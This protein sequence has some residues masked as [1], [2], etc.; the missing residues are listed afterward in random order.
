MSDADHF[1]RVHELSQVFMDSSD[2]IVLQ[3]IRRGLRA[4]LLN[5][6]PGIRQRPE[7]ARLGVLTK[8]LDR[9]ILERDPAGAS[10]AVYNM[11]GAVRERIGLALA[12][13]HA[14]RGP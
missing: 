9:A 14:E 2:N 12:E 5:V 11:W 10:E 6:M 3:I 8:E 7:P 1:T 4:Q 13:A